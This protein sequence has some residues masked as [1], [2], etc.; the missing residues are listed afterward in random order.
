MT[1]LSGVRSDWVQTRLQD[2]D[3]LDVSDRSHSLVK[4]YGLTARQIVE[5]NGIAFTSPAIEGDGGWV[6]NT[7][8]KKL[9]NGRWVF[10]SGSVILLPPGGPRA[11]VGGGG[12]GGGGSQKPAKAGMGLMVGFLGLLALGAWAYK[13]AK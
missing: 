11:A 8:G 13:K 12:G 10:S 3:Q 7:G 1:Y 2:D 5:G 6:E 9:S 4:L